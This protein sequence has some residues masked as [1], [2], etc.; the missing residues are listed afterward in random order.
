MK[1]RKG[2]VIGM[3][4]KSRLVLQLSP[5]LAHDHSLM[6]SS[7]R[8]QITIFHHAQA[9]VYDTSE[10]Q[11]LAIL[12]LA[13]G[14]MKSS[15]LETPSLHFQLHRPYG[16]SIKKSLHIFLQKRRDRIKQSL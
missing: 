14:E 1:D 4:K 7:T 15:N 6:C 3:K 10:L 5:P 12:W 16:L 13:R 2:K 9:G 8:K 11:A